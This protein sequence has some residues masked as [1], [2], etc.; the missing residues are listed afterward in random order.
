MRSTTLSADARRISP[1]RAQGGRKSSRKPLNTNHRVPKRLRARSPPRAAS[2]QPA[3]ASRRLVRWM[4]ALHSQGRLTW[5]FPPRPYRICR[6]ASAA[7]S[8]ISSAALAGD[9]RERDLVEAA[10]RRGRRS[11]RR[12]RVSWDPARCLPAASVDFGGRRPHLWDMAG[13]GAAA[14]PRQAALFHRPLTPRIARALARQT[15]EAP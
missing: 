14:S 9:L 15:P 12:E 7:I 8:S 11:S 1:H 5:S 10:Q 6:R 4:V 3:R 13:R 2:L